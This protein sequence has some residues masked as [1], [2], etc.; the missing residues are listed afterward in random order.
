L[1]SLAS[2]E[3]T[4]FTQAETEASLFRLLQFR[5][6]SAENTSKIKAVQ[7]NPFKQALF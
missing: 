3:K 4:S 2:Q 5:L 6:I 7:S 1:V